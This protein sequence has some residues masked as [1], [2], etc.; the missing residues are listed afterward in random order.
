MSVRSLS[1]QGE[2]LRLRWLLTARDDQLPP[3][4]EDDWIG[5]WLRSGRGAGKT[6]SGGEWIADQARGLPKTRW[7]VVAPTQG[8]CRDICYEGESGLLSIIAGDEIQDYLKSELIIILKNGSKI[9]GF[10][11]EKPDRLRGPQCHGGWLEEISSWENAKA[12][13]DMFEFGLRLKRADGRPPRFVVTSTPKKNKITKELGKDARIHI[14]TASTYDNAENLAPDF[15]DR[16]RTKYEGTLLGQQELHGKVLPD[17]EGAMW[18]STWI[19]LATQAIRES[20]QSRNY[21]SARVGW[22]P[23]VT[24]KDKSDMHG[25][26]AMCRL[27]NGDLVVLEDV[28]DV[29]TPAQGAMRAAKLAIKWGSPEV[30]CEDNQGKDTWHNVWS[31]AGAKALGVRL[32]LQSAKMSKE[33]RSMPLAQAYEQEHSRRFPEDDQTPP[34]DGPA[35]W[36]MPGLEELE[37][38][39]TSWVP[40]ETKGHSPNRIDGLVWAAWRLGIKAT[41]S[42]AVERAGRMSELV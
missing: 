10:S 25:I 2:F 19:M 14:V 13:L 7:H 21:V 8:D 6:R 17:A 41:R 24:S 27:N 1:K 37:E 23:A 18:K 32:T 22:D 29:L 38:E 26:V 11:A 28:S 16:M 30:L 31:D 20:V 39:L 36:H 5:W 34:P 9:K 42:T 4:D 33:E 35:V 3:A 40:M 15:F 12:T